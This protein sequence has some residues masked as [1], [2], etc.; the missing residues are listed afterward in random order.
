M[1]TSIIPTMERMAKFV[2]RFRQSTYAEE[3]S[4]IYDVI[5]SKV[6]AYMASNVSQ[7]EQSIRDTMTECFTAAKPKITSSIVNSFEC[8]CADTGFV[9]KIKKTLRGRA[10]YH[11][12]DKRSE[13]SDPDPD[14]YNKIDPCHLIEKTEHTN[15]SYSN[16]VRQIFYIEL[17][18]RILYG[19]INFVEKYTYIAPQCFLQDISTHLMKRKGAMI[20]ELN[21]NDV[22][23]ALARSILKT[24]RIPIMIDFIEYGDDD[25]PS[26][27]SIRL[28][29][30]VDCIFNPKMTAEY[31][32]TD[33]AL[34]AYISTLN[35]KVEHK[36]DAVQV[37]LSCISGDIGIHQTKAEYLTKLYDEL[38]FRYTLACAK[39]I[40]GLTEESASKAF[41]KFLAEPIELNT[42]ICSDDMLDIESYVKRR[43]SG[44][45]YAE[46]MDYI[47]AIRKHIR[48]HDKD[49]TDAENTNLCSVLQMPGAVRFMF[50]NKVL[51]ERSAKIWDAMDGARDEISQI[52]EALDSDSDSNADPDELYAEQY[53]KMDKLKAELEYGTEH[54]CA[55]SCGDTKLKIRFV[56]SELKE[57]TV[58]GKLIN[59]ITLDKVHAFI[60]E[61]EKWKTEFLKLV[62]LWLIENRS[63]FVAKFEFFTKR[64]AWLINSDPEYAVD[65]FVLA[66]Y[67]GTADPGGH[68]IQITNTDE[69]SYIHDSY[70]DMYWSK[71]E[72]GPHKSYYDIS[73][74]DELQA[75]YNRILNVEGF[76]FK[77][78]DRLNGIKIY[79]PAEL[80]V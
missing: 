71:H 69:Y 75:T 30:Y 19:V 37:V 48:H 27:Y 55:E 6:L 47:C 22:F 24:D 13:Y 25:F 57:I 5:R 64:R 73:I 42:Y 18:Q 78:R 31:G 28:N 7:I 14:S 35:T 2:D 4:K 40:S 54:I 29:F 34:T 23:V 80:L 8:G 1:D 62:E 3:E 39:K 9:T 53:A 51:E 17:D 74:T 36:I 11:G 38:C 43:G 21:N 20:R 66:D 45:Q 67:D 33:S 61:R 15:S 63:K 52:E 12:S 49:I 32:Y 77:F 58:F 26:T 56:P 10:K 41:Q 59:S 72:Y 65:N 60:S 70:H 68:F 76:V 16:K 50:C 46:Q 79:P 44:M